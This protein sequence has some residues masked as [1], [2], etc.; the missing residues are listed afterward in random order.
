MKHDKKLLTWANNRL[1][2][3]FVY[4]SVYEIIDKAKS[5]GIVFNVYTARHWR[6]GLPAI[7]KYHR[8]GIITSTRRKFL[9]AFV[10]QVGWVQ[11]DLGF[12][13]WHGRKYGQF[14]IA[15]DCL[16][17]VTY[18]ESIPNKSFK[19]LKVF[20][21]NLIKMPGFKTI[22]RV[23]TDKEAAL[24][25]NNILHLEE[26]FPGVRFFRTLRHA[27]I[28]ER[29]I[30]TFKLYISKAILAHNQS[31]L[32]WRT[33][34]D[35]VLIKLNYRKLKN[36]NIRPIDFTIKKA[37][38]Y[39]TDLIET[40]P[41]YKTNLYGIGLPTRESTLS[42]LFAFKVH[43]IV[44][45]VKP[46]YP[47]KKIQEKYKFETRSIAGHIDIHTE[48]FEVIHRQLVSDRNAFLIPLYAIKMI[49]KPSFKLTKVYEEYIRQYHKPI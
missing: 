25:P 43:D 45:V 1:K 13:T 46:K 10:P 7:S 34:I 49:S 31:Y 23:L 12:M 15:I 18:V 6:N 27:Q 4:P 36:T 21:E 35:N 22:R 38:Q 2:K 17:K 19:S 20:F 48:P 24:S 3:E 33:H 8:L 39:V 9:P 32:K 47:D 37:A 16:S 29:Q 42:K 5:L 28:V 26:L 40:N 14:A 44:Y 30:R 11:V 41:G